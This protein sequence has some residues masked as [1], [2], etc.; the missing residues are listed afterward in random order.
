[1]AAGGN[2][3]VSREPD[4]RTPVVH[5]PSETL[6]YA[7]HDYQWLLDRDYPDQ[8]ALQL[9]GN[10]FRLSRTERGML[11]R[12][13]FSQAASRTR[14][15][16]LIVPDALDAEP[17]HAAANTGDLVID[18]HNVLFTVWNCLAGRPLVRATDGFIRDIGG[19]RGRLPHDQR[20]TRVAEL[21]CATMAA[22]GFRSI[23][24]L[25]DAQLP[26]SR[27]Q[28]AE[29]AATWARGGFAATEFTA[30]VH[31]SV[32]AAV[33]ASKDATIATSDTG[34][35]DRC[36]QPVLDLG[37]RIVTGSFRAVPL[38]MEHLCVT[39]AR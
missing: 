30:A 4:D 36:R 21:L 6:A 34:I 1:M 7:A 23:S 26:W 5:T 18:G 39:G 37:G 12:G 29:L 27:D 28:S 20:F 38:E 22:A 11:F 8:Q 16:R 33:A 9:C 24:M 2:Q 10:R 32:D 14:S 17:S 19:T 13:V 31:E 25:L 15:E 3:R 35:I